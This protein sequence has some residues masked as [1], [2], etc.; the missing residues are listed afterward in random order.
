M[1]GICKVWNRNSGYGFIQGMDGVNYFVHHNDL[2]DSHNLSINRVVEYDAQYTTK[3][4]Q[5]RNV[6]HA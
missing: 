2:I 4:A 1:V 5:A 6:R 3:G